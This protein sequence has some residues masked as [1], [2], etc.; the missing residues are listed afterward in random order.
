M[1]NRW[2]CS[3][4]AERP[5]QVIE[6][7]NLRGIKTL[8]ARVTIEGCRVARKPLWKE[9]EMSWQ[10]L[11]DERRTARKDHR[12]YL[13]GL[14]ILAGSEHIARTG[15]RDRESCAGQEA[16]FRNYELGHAETQEEETT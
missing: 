4:C 1:M 16:E 7:N 5:M 2:G 8:I 10:H 12:C 3:D 14:P 9:S 11:R 15:T 13:C 6:T